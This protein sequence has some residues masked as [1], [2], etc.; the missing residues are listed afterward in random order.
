[1]IL[2]Y[3][4]VR[5]E[6]I[7]AV[8]AV[9]A[10]FHDVLITLT[11]FSILD[12]EFTLSVLA[13]I[14]TVVGY[15]VNDTIVIFDRIRENCRR[16]ENEVKRNVSVFRE[17]VNR[18][19]NQT[20]SRTLL[21]SSTTIVILIAMFFFGGEVIH[22]FTFTLLLGIVIGTYSSIFVASPIVVWWRSRKAA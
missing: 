18:S 16:K 2:L 8:A 13:A 6:W 9:L 3:V 14:L 21:T 19:I 17:I 4:T 1:M 7:Y 12:K 5:F 20:L 22:D 15:S 11:A 10:L